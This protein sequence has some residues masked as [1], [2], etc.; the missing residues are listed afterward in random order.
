MSR[1]KKFAGWMF[2]GQPLVGKPALT[3]EEAVVDF[4]LRRLD[5]H[6]DEFDYPM[7]KNHRAST[8]DN[9]VRVYD[10]KNNAV[11]DFVRSS[12]LVHIPT[13]HIFYDHRVYDAKNNAVVDIVEWADEAKKGPYGPARVEEKFKKQRSRA[14]LALNDLMDWVEK[15]DAP[16]KDRA[17][18]EAGLCDCD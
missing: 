16:A 6:I 5:T 8:A 10:A 7:E 17:A 15:T 13:G 9:V 14:A 2:Y 12:H 3:P 11:V 1:L 4:F 18:C